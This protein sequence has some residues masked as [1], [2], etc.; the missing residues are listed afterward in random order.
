MNVGFTL[1][2]SVKTSSVHWVMGLKII[3]TGMKLALGAGTA[4]EK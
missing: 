4:R 2:L 1:L 3:P